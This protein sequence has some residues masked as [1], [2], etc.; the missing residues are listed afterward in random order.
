MVH[1]NLHICRGVAIFRAMVCNSN[2]TNI[3][4]KSTMRKSNILLPSES[5]ENE[6]YLKHLYMKH[7]VYKNCTKKSFVITSCIFRN[8]AVNRLPHTFY[9]NLKISKVLFYDSTL[10]TDSF[11]FEKVMQF[12]VISLCEIRDPLVHMLTQAHPLIDIVGKYNSIFQ[13]RYIPIIPLEYW[14]FAVLIR[15]GCSPDKG[16]GASQ[17]GFQSISVWILQLV[18]CSDWLV[19][20]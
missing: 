7:L 19:Y 3:R 17:H 11:F 6:A 18:D 2:W 14:K 20:N 16:S 13:L 1:I 12:L 10:S 9:V 4:N 5:F 8:N 15:T